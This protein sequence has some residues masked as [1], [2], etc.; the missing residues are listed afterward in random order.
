[1]SLLDIS[2]DRRAPADSARTRLVAAVAA[3]M[4]ATGLV[5]AL[6]GPGIPVVEPGRVAAVTDSAGTGR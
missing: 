1:M 5:V 2:P 3:A 4:V 6:S